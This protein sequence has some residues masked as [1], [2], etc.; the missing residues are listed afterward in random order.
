MARRIDLVGTLIA[1]TALATATSAVAG[2]F[3]IS[4][5][6]VELSAQQRTEALT[7]RN[8]SSDRE[9]VVQAQAFA[10]SQADGQDSLTPTRDVIVTPPVFTLA[11]NAQQIVRVAVRRAA[12]PKREL[13]YRLIL[14]EVP[15]EAPKNFTGLQVALRLSLPIFI[16]PQTKGAPNLLWASAWQTDGSLQVTAKNQGDVHAQVIDF[17]VQAKDSATAV[18]KNS[19]VKYVLPGATTTWTL[20][21]LPDANQV[22]KLKQSALVLRGASD[23][24]EITAELPA[25][26]K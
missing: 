2:T 7:V 11:A 8:E 15:P 24:G 21:A 14:Q 20:Q 23:R 3:S 10:W 5:I 18:M 9:V 4:P 6:R 26:S 25:V 1:L 12:D 16:A 13:T 22:T 17:S 19:V